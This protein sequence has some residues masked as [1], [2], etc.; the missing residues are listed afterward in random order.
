MKASR[1]RDE[2]TALVRAATWGALVLLTP[3][4]ASGV[5]LVLSIFAGLAGGVLLAVSGP[6][7]Y[8]LWHAAAQGRPV[9]GWAVRIVWLI[10]IASV[11]I[12]LAVGTIPDGPLEYTE[13]RNAVITSAVVAVW[14][15]CL[16]SCAVVLSRNP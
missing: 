12:A 13:S 7:A 8:E 14:W 11:V 3:V 4:L 2:S 1:A 6:C 10:V 9:R 15:L 5:L 16:A